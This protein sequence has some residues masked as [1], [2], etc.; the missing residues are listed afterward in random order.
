MKKSTSSRVFIALFL[1]LC[2]APSLGILVL[3]PST[4]GYNEILS[5][6]P[7]LKGEDGG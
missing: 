3:G 6:A 4:G 1:A 5:P 7:A 2:L